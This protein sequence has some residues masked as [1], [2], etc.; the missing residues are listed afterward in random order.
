MAT[1]EFALLPC[2]QR[3]IRSNIM[4]KDLDTHLKSHCLNRRYECEY[5]GEEGT[6]AFIAYTHDNSC[7]KKI[8]PCP[9]ECPQGIP[10]EDIQKH[11]GS[12]CLNTEVACKYKSIGCEAVLRRGDMIKHEQD[13]RI[14]LHKSLDT[15][16]KLQRAV[17]DL[18]NSFAELQENVTVDRVNGAEVQRAVA[19]VEND[20][21]D[22]WRAVI[23][24]STKSGE[25]LSEALELDRQQGNQ[26]QEARKATSMLIRCGQP[27]T[28]KVTGFQQKKQRNKIFTLPPF[29]TSPTGYFVEINVFANGSHSGEGTHVSVFAL[30]KKGKYDNEILWPFVGEM[31]FTLLNQLRDAN[32]HKCV[33][34]IDAGRDSKVGSHCG[35][36]QFIPHTKLGCQP[37]ENTQYLKNNTLYFRVFVE[38][39]GYKH[40]LECTSDS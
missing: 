11:I 32:H 4:R 26:H 2:P 40:W 14:H 3:C 15:I 31:T 19:N 33:L 10:R 30:L 16:M 21:A 20:S 36:Y 7:V 39:S 5:C 18:Q 34:P 27:V 25:V 35:F 38:A 8:V 29:Y 12:E 22:L 9:N 13:D 1:C 23:A 28:F 6:Y 17:V 24:N 37:I